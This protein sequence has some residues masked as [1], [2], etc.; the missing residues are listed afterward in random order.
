MLKQLF[1]FLFGSNVDKAQKEIA[2]RVVGEI[3]FHLRHKNVKLDIHHREELV[4]LD[5]EQ[6]YYEDLGFEVTR[7]TSPE[8]RRAVI[9]TVVIEPISNEACI[10]TDVNIKLHKR[11]ETKVLHS[12]D[13]I[14]TARSFRSFFIPFVEP[15]TT[16][17]IESD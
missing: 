13:F 14:N 2:D 5:I 1:S 7:S 8:L 10:W 12:A 15:L 4:V 16:C 9:A 17:L 3:E 11:R 6:I